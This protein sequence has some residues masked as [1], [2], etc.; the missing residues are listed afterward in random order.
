MRDGIGARERRKAG[1]AVGRVVAIGIGDVLAWTGIMPTRQAAVGVVARDLL[2]LARA[3]RTQ[4][5]SA[6]RCRPD[7]CVQDSTQ[8]S[9]R[10]E[11]KSHEYPTPVSVDVEVGK[12]LA[13]ATKEAN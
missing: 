8:A 12:T 4:A 11:I 10:A 5:S 1:H 6:S 9:S 13:A 2:H 7:R 3:T